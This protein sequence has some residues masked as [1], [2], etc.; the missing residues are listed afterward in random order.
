MTAILY[1]VAETA[2]GALHAPRG[3]AARESEARALHGEVRFVTEIAGPA[4]AT[5]EAALDAYAG[6]VEDERPGRPQPERQALWARLAAV[7]SAD[8]RPVRKAPAKPVYR[9]G[10]RWPQTPAGAAP[11]LWRLAVSYWKLETA[12]DEPTGSARKLRR[13]E[14]GRELDARALAALTRQPLAPV[15]PQQPLDIGLFEFRLPEAPDIVVP[16]E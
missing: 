9:D 1:P 6:R 12:A 13:S 5:R 7:S 15:K 10:R 3:H 16:D 8:G 11:T 4:F 2:E 14:D